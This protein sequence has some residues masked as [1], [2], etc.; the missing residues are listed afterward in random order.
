MSGGAT[1]KLGASR[2]VEELV[3][4]ISTG[5][6]Q[7]ERGQESMNTRWED[8]A[9]R[10]PDRHMS[11][12]HPQQCWL[13]GPTH[14]GDDDASADVVEEPQRQWG[15]TAPAQGRERSQSRQLRSRQT[16]ACA[17]REAA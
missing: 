13:H 4:I 7:P 1:S 5:E 2:N 8:G 16:C 14:G 6:D 17:M 9:R 10:T 11:Q 3:V 15:T 12:Q